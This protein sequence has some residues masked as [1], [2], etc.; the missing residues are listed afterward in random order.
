MEERQRKRA[1]RSGVTYLDSAEL[2][3]SGTRNESKL[4]GV[5]RGVG[6]PTND[7]LSRRARR[8]SDVNEAWASLSRGKLAEP[9]FY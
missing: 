2:N 6:E 3:A 8:D 5:D 4:F 7:S 1:G 9:E